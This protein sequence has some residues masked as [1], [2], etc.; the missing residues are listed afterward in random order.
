MQRA[1]RPLLGP[2]APV[3]SNKRLA[4]G[5]VKKNRKR[6]FYRNVWGFVAL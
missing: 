2:M 1:Y 3:M 6:A 4:R 5:G